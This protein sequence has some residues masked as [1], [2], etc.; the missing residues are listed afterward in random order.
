MRLWNYYM[1]MA[2]NFWHLWNMVLHLFLQGRG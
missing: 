1:M 2:Q